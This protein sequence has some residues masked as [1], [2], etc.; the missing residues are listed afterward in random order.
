MQCIQSTR[1]QFQ[2]HCSELSQT[3]LMLQELLKIH[4]KKLEKIFESMNHMM[5][6]R[7]SAVELKR[8]SGRLLNRLVMLGKFRPL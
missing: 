6:K 5:Q 7:V 8:F 4:N 3:C 2:L 1:F